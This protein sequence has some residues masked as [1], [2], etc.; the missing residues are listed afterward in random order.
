MVTE[1]QDRIPQEWINQLCLEQEHWAQVLME[2]YGWSTPN[3]HNLLFIEAHAVKPKKADFR[4]VTS[5]RPP[6]AQDN[7]CEVYSRMRAIQN[8]KMTQWHS[9][10]HI[11]YRYSVSTVNLGSVGNY[12]NVCAI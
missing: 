2:R 8:R 11:C 10:Q 6:V 4:V 7:K 5:T 3:Q 9:I 1:E 12:L